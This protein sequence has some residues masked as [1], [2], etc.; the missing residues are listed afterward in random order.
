ML[1]IFSTPKPFRGHIGVIQRNALESWK[2]IHPDVE[3]ILFGDEE[4]A[5]EISQLLGIRHVPHVER[6]EHGTKYLT[7]IFDQAQELARHPT[8][9]YVNCDI[10]LMSDFRRALE[11]VAARF[12]RFLMVGRRWDTD[13]AG[14]VDFHD[15]EWESRLQRRAREANHPRPSEWID[16]FAFSRGLYFRN[17]PPLVIGRPGWDNWL[18]WKARASGASMVDASAVIL[19]VHQNHDYSYHPDGKAGV[20]QGAEAQKNYAFHKRGWCF[21]TMEDASHLLTPAGL[22]QNPNRWKVL[23]KRTSRALATSVWFSALDLTRP[24]RHRLGLRRRTLSEPAIRNR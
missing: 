9:C 1:T 2:R 7:S 16:Y 18:L 3:I 8:L 14:P 23:A 20:W 22:Q 13:V 5:A 12:E 6:N 15:A 17:T 24:V 4:G 21:G 11:Q 10:V 19:V